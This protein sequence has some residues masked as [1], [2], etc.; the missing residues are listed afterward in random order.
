MQIHLVVQ[1][2]GSSYD[3]YSERVLKAF[4][5]VEKAEAYIVKMKEQD[6]RYNELVK[7]VRDHAQDIQARIPQP[8]S[9][10]RPPP[11]S[12][13]SSG[14]KKKDWPQ[15]YWDAKTEVD[16]FNKVAMAKHEDDLEAW[17]A[18]CTTAAT[19]M[20]VAIGAT[21]E[22]RE[23][24]SAPHSPVPWYASEHGYFYSIEV[25]ELE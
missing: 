4:M 11:K 20:W 22:E 19:E 23:R 3:D 10:Y 13:S 16:A 6:V 21:E 17:T 14:I 25:T 18:A 9:P 12:P 2:E 1:G 24:F 5:E 7:Q 15:T 8:R